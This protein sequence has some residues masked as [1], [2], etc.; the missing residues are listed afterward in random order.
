MIRYL[1]KSTVT[2]TLLLAGAALPLQSTRAEEVTFNLETATLDDLQQAL[3]SGAISSVQLVTIYL[4]RRALYDQAG[5]KLNSIVQISPDVMAQAEAADLRRAAGQKVGPLDGV[6]F[7]TKDSYNSVGL[8]STGGV[9][10]WKDIFPTSDSFIVSRLKQAGAILL[11]H[12][13]MDTFANSA[14]NTVSD[15]FG[16]TLNAYTLGVPAGSS[17]GPAVATA[18]D[19]AFF[20]FGGETGGSIRNPSD[21]GGIVGFKVGV[22]TVSVD[23]VLA[24]VPD[25]DVIGPMAR[26]TKDEATI[27]EVASAQDP[28][29]IWSS[30]VN[31]IPGRPRPSGFLAKQETA[32]LQGKKF[33]IIGTYVGQPYPGPNPPG[34]TSNTT[35]VNQISQEI[36]TIFNRA[37]S[38]IE[39]MGGTTVDV[40][41]PPD[42]DTAVALGA[43][44]PTRALVTPSANA[45]N[46]QAFAHTAYLTGLGQDPVTRLS[47]VPGGRISAALLTAVQNHT[48]ISFT[49]PQG[50]EHFQA[51]KTYANKFETWMNQ[52]GFDA[53]IWPT[54]TTKTRTSANPPGRDIVNNM[55]MPLCTVPMGVIAS[56]GEP[57]TL[58]FCGRFRSEASIL[59]L[60][61]AYEQNT[62]YRIPSPLAPPMAEESFVYTL[63][64]PAPLPPPLPLVA[65]VPEEAAPETEVPVPPQER[66]DKLAPVVAIAGK[67][68]K[69][70]ADEPQVQFS[71]VALDQSGIQSIQVYVNGVQIPATPRA[72]WSAVMPLKTV[73]K[74]KVTGHR[75]V[76][77]LVLVRDNYGN[78]SAKR[79]SVAIS[80]SH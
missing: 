70:T 6:P 50:L 76:D 9:N 7:V 42:L 39:A 63:P 44:Q 30:V 15:A 45:T 78:T 24:L 58:A 33:G 31:Y 55:G 19:M 47:Q 21:R 5:I 34:S 43:G 71:G 62:N 22:G 52:N 23:G 11:G 2:A 72:Q 1:A 59:A 8:A 79:K 29:D 69:L 51:Q 57:A 32:K 37:R 10:A 13:N 41:L 60:A 48:G 61:H 4:N 20:A 3:D 74:L 80:A 46:L 64:A 17:G 66:P 68:K 49:S 36:L 65:K 77:V 27:M 26:Y 56:T 14:T 16:A 35:G 28:R 54:H 12:A 25:R 18:S 38:E 53:L 67:V 75:K 73:R 40:F